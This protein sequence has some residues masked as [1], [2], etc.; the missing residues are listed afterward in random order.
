[1]RVIEVA[2]R[3]MGKPSIYPIAPATLPVIASLQ[4]HVGVPGLSAPDNPVYGGSAAHAPNEH[5]RID[6]F[7][8]AIEFTIAVL[9]ELGGEPGKS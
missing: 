6:D 3:V 7:G 1:V 2:E 9:D 4:R 5:I 8:P